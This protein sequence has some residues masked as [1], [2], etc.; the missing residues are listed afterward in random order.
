MVPMRP[1][2]HII[3]TPRAASSGKSLEGCSDMPRDLTRLEFRCIAWA[4]AGNDSLAS[5]TETRQV[6]FPQRRP[7]WI[8]QIGS[9][10]RAL[11]ST[12]RSSDHKSKPPSVKLLA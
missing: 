9:K 7:P 11:Y 4:A 8:E 2:T 3:A 10:I 12:E 5:Y 6:L 1:R